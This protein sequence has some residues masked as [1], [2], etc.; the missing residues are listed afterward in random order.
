MNSLRSRVVH[1][2]SVLSI[3]GTYL[4]DE[5]NVVA[6]A[7][8]RLRRYAAREHLAE[9]TVRVDETSGGGPLLQVASDAF[10]WL[11][12]VYGAQAWEWSRGQGYRLGALRG[13]VYA[14]AHAAEPI[15]LA[16]LSLTVT[17][18]V[19][20]PPFT[21]EQD[22]AYAACF[23]TWQACAVQPALEPFFEAGEPVFPEIATAH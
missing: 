17:R 11:K 16:G 5:D 22:V 3:I 7:T 21:S 9:V 10:V 1:S 6:E 20:R 12:D 15:T 14:L 2:A 19:A 8:Y 23:A 4:V 13:V 18:I